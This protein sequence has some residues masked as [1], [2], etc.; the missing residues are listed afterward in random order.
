[1]I[2][3]HRLFKKKLVNDLN[4]IYLIDFLEEWCNGVWKYVGVIRD[5]TEEIYGRS[6]Y[7]GI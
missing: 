5:R 4:E 6:V 3:G 1:M 7:E 2:G